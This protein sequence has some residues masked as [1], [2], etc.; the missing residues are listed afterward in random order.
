MARETPFPT[1]NAGDSILASDLTRIAQT[2]NNLSAQTTGTGIHSLRSSAGSFSSQENPRPFIYAK[3]TKKIEVTETPLSGSGSGSGSGANNCPDNSSGASGTSGSGSGCTPTSIIIHKY[4]WRQMYEQ[5]GTLYDPIGDDVVSSP[6]MAGSADRLEEPQYYWPAYELNN[7]DVDIGTIVQLYFGWGPW[8][9]FNLGGF[10]VGGP[11]YIDVITN[12]C[13]IYE[14]VEPSIGL[15]R[16]DTE[17]GITG[18]PITAQGTIR[19]ENTISSAG[20]T[21][22]GISQGTQFK[23]ADNSLQLW[24]NTQ[25]R[26]TKVLSTANTLPPQSVMRSAPILIDIPAMASQKSF[27]VM[28]VEPGCWETFEVRCSSFAATLEVRCLEDTQYGSFSMSN[29]CFQ[30]ES[31]ALFEIRR[32][33]N[34]QELHLCYRPITFEAHQL[35]IK[36]KYDLNTTSFFSD[37]V[38][39]KD[40]LLGFISQLNPER[41][42]R[43]K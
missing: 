34:N 35:Q 2:T 40:Q 7:R 10:G 36:A 16:I 20:T 4:S 22:S 28:K 42:W 39:N 17:N 1:Y 29:S 41:T 30:I 37:P 31:F 14:E 11:A 8:L 3:I 26:V 13:P 21:L 27:S 24:I 33:E 9:Y 5:D 12:I 25:G 6:T 38:E 43:S 18:G 15:T 32:N 19:L 23:T